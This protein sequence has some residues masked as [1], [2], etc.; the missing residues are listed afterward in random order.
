MTAAELVGV[1]AVVG[2]GCFFGGGEERAQE[3]DGGGYYYEGV[4]YYY[5]AEEEDCV[6]WLGWVVSLEFE[7]KGLVD[8]DGGGKGRGNYRCNLSVHRGSLALLF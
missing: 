8:G 6:V 1:A 7:G 2:Y 5:P 3:G 4:F